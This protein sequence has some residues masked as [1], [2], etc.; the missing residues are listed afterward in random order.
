MIHRQSD[1]QEQA[2]GPLIA[3]CEAFLDGRYRQF[4]ERRGKPVPAWAWL[5]CLAHGSTADIT[6]VA[7]SKAY[8]NS[9]A[10]LVA[11]LSTAVL[12]RLD[13]EDDSLLRLQESKLLPLE[14]KLYKYAGLTVPQSAA[15]LTRW[16]VS[17]LGLWA[18]E[19]T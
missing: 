12:G 10:Q 4:L 16:V 6:A 14:S 13:R 8:T 7:I 18:S 9:P 11:E 15:E 3:E 1:T 2:A 19:G 5:D 17:T